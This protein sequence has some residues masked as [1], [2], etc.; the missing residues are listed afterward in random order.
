MVLN[1]G[2]SCI[3]PASPAVFAGSRLK[4]LD[5]INPEGYFICDWCYLTSPNEPFTG[6]W[7]TYKRSPGRTH[8]SGKFRSHSCVDCRN[9]LHH[10][11]NAVGRHAI[12][13]HG[14]AGIVDRKFRFVM[15]LRRRRQTG[16]HHHQHMS[17]PWAV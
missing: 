5:L 8:R 2:T 11:H 13:H 3:E 17:K 14:L 1:M 12:V 6:S 16:Q 4:H 7:C 15:L 10:G 9:R